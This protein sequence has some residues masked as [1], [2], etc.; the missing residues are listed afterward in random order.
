MAR[1]SAW[2]VIGLLTVVLAIGAAGR[3]LGSTGAR[4]EGVTARITSGAES[5]VTGTP[6]DPASENPYHAS[7]PALL[8]AT[9]RPQL[10][11]FYHRL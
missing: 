7:D 4:P 11:E 5:G 6:A 3:W 8:A 2:L 10:V 9:L 1:R